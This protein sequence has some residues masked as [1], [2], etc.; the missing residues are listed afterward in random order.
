MGRGRPSK[1]LSKETVLRA[2]KMTRSNFAAARY[3]HVSYP[4]YAEYA[5][6]YKDEETGSSLHE[7]HKN[8]AGVGIPKFLTSKDKQPALLDIVEGRVP[9]EHFS[10][11]KL[12][13]RIILEGVL[14]EKCNKCGFVERRVI[15]TKVPLILSH[16]DG[17]TNNFLFENLEFLCYNCSFL[18]AASAITEKQVEAME[19][20]VDRI[21]PDIDWQLDEHHIEHLK[22]L[23]LFE[24]DDKRPGEEYISRL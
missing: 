24:D 23:G 15:D 17:N 19:D 16:K 18:Y 2:M 20:F 7:L 14:E 9:A 1:I 12:K 3:C 21:T 11:Q 13:Q 8:Q 4:H 22:S 10:P 5:K 6:M